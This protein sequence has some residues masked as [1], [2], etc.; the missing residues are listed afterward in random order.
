MLQS[1]I[2]FALDQIPALVLFGIAYL[3]AHKANS[4]DA[5]AISVVEQV[6]MAVVNAKPSPT[7]AQANATKAA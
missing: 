5:A 7:P 1:I 4:W 2:N 6:A 3:K